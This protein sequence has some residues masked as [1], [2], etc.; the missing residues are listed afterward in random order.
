M[1]LVRA[2][3]TLL[4][5]DYPSSTRAGAAER[6]GRAEA[7]THGGPVSITF[8]ARN[9]PARPRVGD[10][11]RCPLPETPLIRRTAPKAR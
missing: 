10:A 1:W 11:W 6:V 8:Q 3:R 2:K 4:A 9:C 5:V 7:Q